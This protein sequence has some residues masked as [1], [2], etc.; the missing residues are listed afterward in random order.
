MAG[1]KLGYRAALAWIARNDDT[2][3]LAYNDA[4]PSVALLLV[5]DIF[6]MDVDKAARDLRRAIEKESNND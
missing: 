4:A 1:R 6:G 3:W 2:E 5:A